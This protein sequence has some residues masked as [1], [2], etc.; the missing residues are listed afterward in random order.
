MVIC[1]VPVTWKRGPVAVMVA[2]LTTG[3]ENPM[4][5]LAATE[6]ELVA[7]EKFEKS[8]YAP[9]AT[10]ALPLVELISNAQRAKLYAT[11]KAKKVDPHGAC[12]TALNHPVESI[13]EITKSE[14][15]LVIEYLIALP[16]PA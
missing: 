5:L 14:A 7:G 9:A 16:T 15:H 11:A 1:V 12:A 3:A 10:G 4:F 6:N 2:A 8:E 13:S